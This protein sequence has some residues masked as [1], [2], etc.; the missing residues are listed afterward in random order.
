MEDT[1]PEP[2]PQPHPGATA[3][4]ARV[5]QLMSRGRVQTLSATLRLDEVAPR[6]RRIGHNCWPVLDADQVVGLLLQRDL[7]RALEHDLGALSVRDIMQTGAICLREDEEL[8]A[9]EAALAS[10]G[11][12][13]VAVIDAAGQLTG[14]VSRGDLL[15]HSATAPETMRELSLTD[16]PQAGLILRIADEARRANIAL[17]LVGGTVRDLLLGRPCDDID[18][19]VKDSPHRFARALRK[20]LGGRLNPPTPFGTLRWVLD[21]Q[22]AAEVGLAPDQLPAHVDFAATR[23]ETY[24]HPAVLPDVYRSSLRQDLGRRDFSINALAVQVAPQSGPVIDQFGGLADLD[25]GRI[26]VLHSLSFWDDPLRIVRAW[27][28]RARFGFELETR[29]AELM[30][31]ARPA[32]GRVTGTRLRNELELLLQEDDPGSALLA[33]QQAGLLHAMHPAFCVPADISDR[34][35]RVLQ[36]SGSPAPPA[37]LTRL[38]HALATGIAPDMLAAYCERMLFPPK[39][40]RSLLG[41]TSLLHKAGPLAEPGANT[42]QIVER[43]GHVPFDAAWCVWRLTDHPLVRARIEDYLLRW[44]QTRALST[45]HEL[46]AAGLSPGPAMGRILLQLRVAWYDGAISNAPEENNLLQ[47]LVA[48]EQQVE[49]EDEDAQP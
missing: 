49:R 5:A 32:L 24:A 33:M 17:W 21:E 4:S 11:L 47:Q 7:E 18:F 48:A 12:S 34:L 45:G 41:A 39:L 36:P 23:A 16:M 42:L 40:G 37:R 3:M 9:L 29:T 28:F 27:R 31:V 44:P 20:R 22:L 46:R 8:P 43:L 14:M 35:R 26:R 25:A 10:H 1:N 13:S 6:L 2:G 15:R 30:Q 19:L 38:W